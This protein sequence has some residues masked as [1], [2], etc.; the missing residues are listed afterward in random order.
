MHVTSPPANGIDAATAA[1]THARQRLPVFVPD[2][3]KTIV[4]P[5]LARALTRTHLAH[6]AA[7]RPRFEQGFRRLMNRAQREL[8]VGRPAA[9]VVPQAQQ[10]LLGLLRAHDL[11]FELIPC[12][13]RRLELLMGLPKPLDDAVSFEQWAASFNARSGRIE[14]QRRIAVAASRHVL[15]RLHQRLGTTSA[16]TVLKE[17]LAG[18]RGATSMLEAAHQADARHWPLLGEQGLFVCSASPGSTPAA[19]ITWMRRDQ[20]GR[21]WGRLS[22]DLLAARAQEEALLH[23]QQYLVELLRLH[24]WTLQ[25]HCPGP[26]LEAAAWSSREVS[27]DC[28]DPPSGAQA[29][30]ESVGLSPSITPALY[31]PGEGAGKPAEYATRAASESSSHA[32]SDDEEEELPASGAQ[33]PRFCVKPRQ[34]LKGLVVQRRGPAM[35]VLSV[36][37]G[38]FGILRTAASPGDHNHEGDTG[39]K[40]GQRVEVEV[41]RTCGTRYTGASSIE[42]LTVHEALA[43][44]EQACKHYTVD[45]LV[46][47]SGAWH[48]EGG[49]IVTLA[50][51]TTGWLPDE[52]LSWSKAARR[53]ELRQSIGSGGQLRV[54]G[55]S[56]KRRQLLLS[57]RQVVPHPLLSAEAGALVGSVLDAVVTDVVHFGAFVQLPIGVD[58]LLHR[59]QVPADK[60]LHPNDRV[61]VR[62]TIVDA[63]KRRVAVAW[64]APDHVDATIPITVTA[65]DGAAANASPSGIRDDTANGPHCADLR[66]S[67]VLRL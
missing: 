20:L 46:S 8:Q 40:L 43:R 61:R 66:T 36:G 5:S 17:L 34:Q 35:A 37:N 65:A 41:L 27:D 2:R 64:A 13:G 26:D 50:D 9:R 53:T 31:G 12:T 42:L 14:I 32:S 62:V 11:P 19:L 58:A 22:E 25:A 18:M 30:E 54:T 10:Q 55:H 4:D 3:V 63:P 48:T 56:T 7:V 28:G 15:E 1:H 39:P 33:A 24:A 60:T 51:G 23:D 49:T 44:W 52:E 21:R 67:W 6:W 47:I 45:A 38:Q 59:S 29:A 16:L 57:L